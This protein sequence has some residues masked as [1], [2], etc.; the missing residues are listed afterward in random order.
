MPRRRKSGPSANRPLKLVSRGGVESQHEVV[1]KLRPMRCALAPCFS[2][3]YFL[4]QHH[5]STFSLVPARRSTEAIPHSHLNV[6][7]VYAVS[8]SKCSERWSF[9]PFGIASSVSMSGIAS[10]TSFHVCILPGR[11]QLI[12]G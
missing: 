11:H 4:H 9:Q 5:A 12:S 8:L 2:R 6:A 7:L 1:L 3:L 10:Q